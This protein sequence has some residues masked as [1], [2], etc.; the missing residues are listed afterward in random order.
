MPIKRTGNI[1]IVSGVG[2]SRGA[3]RTLCARSRSPVPI[4][5]EEIVGLRSL[6]LSRKAI[7]KATGVSA[8]WV[9]RVLLRVGLT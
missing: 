4:S 9:R 5:T 8:G 6:G 2:A 7:A 1:E 3:G